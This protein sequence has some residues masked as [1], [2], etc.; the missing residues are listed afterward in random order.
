MQKIDPGKLT[1]HEDPQSGFCRFFPLKKM[2]TGTRKITIYF[3][4]TGL[5]DSNLIF[6]S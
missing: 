5:R 3:T 6:S 2:A 4:L 1:F